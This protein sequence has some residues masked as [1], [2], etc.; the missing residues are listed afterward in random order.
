MSGTAVDS[1]FTSIRG[2]DRCHFFCSSTIHTR[3]CQGISIGVGGGA[4]SQVLSRI[5]SNAGLACFL[6]SERIVVV[7]GRRGAR[8]RGGVS[9]GKAIESTRRRPLPKIG[10]LIGNAAVNAAASVSKGCFVDIPSGG[11][12]LIF[13]CVNFRS[14]R[15]GINKRVG[16]G[17]GV[18]RR[19][20]DLS[21]IIIINC[22]SRGE[23]SMI[24]SVATVRPTR[25][26]RKAAHT[27]SGGLTKRL[28]NIVT[29]RHGNRP[30]SSNSSF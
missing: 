11:T 22:N 27:I 14:R 20:G 24:N 28:T 25:L 29:M 5:L 17:I 21:R 3:L 8:R 1:I 23:T 18:S 16:V 26:R 4:V 10:M 12:I 2:G 7:E 13:D 9:V 15:I 19:S 30:K 6:G